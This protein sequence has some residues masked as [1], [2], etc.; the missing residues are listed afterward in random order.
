MSL[1]IWL[2]L[3][4]DLRQQG[5]S[6]TAITNHGAT[7]N[8]NGKLGG[9]YSFDG[10]D[11]NLSYTPSVDGIETLSI[12]FWVC[13][14]AATPAGSFFSLERNTYWQLTFYGNYVA[15]RDNSIGYSGTR[16]NFSTGTYIADTWTHVVV[17]YDKGTLKIYR[18]GSLLSTNSVGGTK[19][20]TSINNA[21][22]GSAVQSGYY[23][24]GKMNDVRIYDHCLSPMEVKQLSQGLVLHYLLNRN[25]WGQENFILE[26]HKVTS[27]GNANGITRTYES[28]GSMKIVSTSG[29]GNYASLGFAQNSNTS[30]GNNMVVGDTYCISCDVKIETGTALPTL[31]INSGNGYKQLKSVN[32]S[33]I[34]NK[35]MRAYYT[36]TWAE[37]GTQ[38]GNISLHLGFSNAIG[39]YY[40]KN[41]KLEKG[42]IPTP[43]CP[44]SSDAL[45]TTMGLNSTIEYDCSGYCNNGTRTGTFSW[46]SDTPKY[47]VSTQFNGT[48]VIQLPFS[49]SVI[50]EAITVACW[51]YESNWNTSSAERLIGAA[52][53][54]SGWCIGDYGSENTLF[55]FYANGGYNVATGFK[56]LTAGWHHFVITFDGLNLKYYVDGQQFSSKTFSTKQV[57]IGNYNIEIGRHYGDG[58]NFKGRM[59]DVRIYATALS[60]DDVKSLYQ[61]C[62]TIDPDG[63][64]RGQIRS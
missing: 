48:Q 7:F 46:T 18:D 30:V 21:R 64:I 22:I 37:P 36:S 49:C 28:D 2:P 10:T 45:A 58:C 32:G 47:S 9:C 59:S 57:A 61:N 13:P 11:D 56:Q 53:N 43:W 39:T 17:T 6:D 24:S 33:I 25:G 26:S 15:I 35:W 23:Y 51:G 16:K 38:Y 14:T 50:S 60:A 31:F 12:A 3:T 55:A 40:F 34:T 41:F 1:Q 52:T 29:N 5:L 44:N 20:N 63:T 27:G 8:S 62:A 4:K 42:S 54:S 19:L